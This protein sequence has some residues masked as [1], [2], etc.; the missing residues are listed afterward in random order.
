MAGFAPS[1]CPSPEASPN[2]DDE[3]DED[4]ASTSGDDDLSMT[5]LLS[6]VTKRG[7]VLGLKVVLYLGGK[8]V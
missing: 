6:F 5:G 4:D 1:P 8:L 2:D 7:V 3:D